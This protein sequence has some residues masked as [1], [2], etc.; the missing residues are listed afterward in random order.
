[1]N[2]LVEIV[3]MDIGDR[4]LLSSLAEEIPRVFPVGC[5]IGHAEPLPGDTLDQAR[6]QYHARRILEHLAASGRDVFRVLGITGV[7]IFTPVLRYVFGE[8]M[9]PGK[10][11]LVSTCRLGTEQP[12]DRP[13]GGRSVFV[14]RV[15]KE[16]IHELGHTF[17]LTHCRDRSCV[18]AASLDMKQV[19]AKSA[20]LCTYC[21]IVLGDNLSP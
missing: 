2:R 14:D 18:M 13:P 9:F 20:R 5:R 6:G 4:E 8:A 16:A 21:R 7:D 11:A 12:P 17:G 10:A 19:D 15:C 1:M 3:P